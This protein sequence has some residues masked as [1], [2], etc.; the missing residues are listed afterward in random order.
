LQFE[1]EASV[2]DSF[3]ANPTK[4]KL[5]P[6]VKNKRN[7]FGKLIPALRRP[8]P[9]D[10]QPFVW[11]CGQTISGFSDIVSPLFM[12]S[13]NSQVN[14]NWYLVHLRSVAL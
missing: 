7:S 11:Q 9:T 13:L 5:I 2:I 14:C 8:V 12:F 10:T 6:T 3:L 1:Q 4:K